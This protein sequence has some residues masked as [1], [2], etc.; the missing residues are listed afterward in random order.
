MAIRADI[1]ER[2]TAEERTKA[3]EKK[4]RF[5]LDNMIEGAQIIDSDWRYMYL[6]NTA[7]RYSQYQRKELI[8]RTMMEKYP[9]IENTEV[10]KGLEKCMHDRVAS[11]M[12]I[13]FVYPNGSIGWFQV[14]AHHSSRTWPRSIAKRRRT[15][16]APGSRITSRVTVMACLL[17]HACSLAPDAPGTP[18]IS[19]RRR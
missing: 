3:S 17:R 15:S 4:L 7:I 5:I 11:Q 6:N 12:E 18:G 2:K 1:T 10:F 14:S 8:G 16:S 9:G 13:K 19:R